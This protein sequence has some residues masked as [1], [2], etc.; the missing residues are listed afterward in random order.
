MDNCPSGQVAGGVF[1]RKTKNPPR[2]HVTGFGTMLLRRRRF[3]LALGFDGFLE[4]ALF[5]LFLLL[6]LVAEE[7]EDSDFRAITHADARGDDARVAA[8]AIGKLRRDLTEELR[9]D[10]RSHQVGS[11]LAAR[12][13]SVALA[14]S[15]DS[16]R[17]GT[18][19]FGARQ[20]GGNPSML[21]KISDQ[22]AQGRAAVPRIASEF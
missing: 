3:W 13:Q 19:R 4:L 22:V 12:L 16:L 11:G 20:R 2:F 18:R 15:D 14:K 21:K 7:L 10:R 17:H 6:E 8:G 9:G 5:F 1:L